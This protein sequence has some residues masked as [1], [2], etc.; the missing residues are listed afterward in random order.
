MTFL[1]PLRRLLVG[2]CLLAAA[3]ALP[4][5]AQD[6]DPIL[7]LPE[8]SRFF[9]DALGFASDSAGVS[10][11][12]LYVEVPHHTLQF[13]KEGETFHASYEA[14]LSVFDSAEQQVA[15]RFW[16]EAI[17][18]KEYDATTSLRMAKLSLKSILLPPGAY[19]IVVQV[20]DTETKKSSR[21]KRL[22]RLRDFA[23]PSF[24]L[25]D[26][27]LILRMSTEE[28]R[29]VI[30]P[31][32]EG[33]VGATND[34]FYVFFESY[35][36]LSADSADVRLTIRNIKTE[37]VRVDSERVFLPAGRKACFAMARSSSL[38]AGDYTVEVQAKLLGPA[39]PGLD[40]T[41]YAVRPFLVRWRGVPISITDLDAALD[42]LQ[43]LLDGDKID[44]MKKLAPEAKRMAFQEFWKKRD[45][46]PGTERNELMEEYYARVAYANKNFGHYTEGWKTDRGMVY[47]I[48]GSPSNIERHPFDTDAKPYEIWTY[49]QIDRE[50]VFVDASGFGDY[51]LQTPIWDVWRTRP[52]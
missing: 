44:D 51:R 12:D 27:M 41:A 34:S 35:N 36:R 39:A 7:Q 29:K 10:R 24:S 16:R 38:M 2:I 52:R 45:P 28:E 13:V 48:F 3:T 5:A 25:S 18:T 20:R 30:Y 33:N 17:D 6:E 43:Y 49:Y 15:E 22:V 47:V 26:P 46:T 8:V 37:T 11:L 14:S 21:V 31:N 23:T 4:A 19:T 40:R 32:V 50:F 42:Q 9:V 1:G